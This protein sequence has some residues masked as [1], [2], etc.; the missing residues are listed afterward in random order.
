MTEG[1]ERFERYLEQLSQGIEALGPEEAAEVVAEVRA[2]L[3]EAVAGAE[4]DRESVIAQFGS[5]EVL[6]ARILEERGVVAGGGGL[7]EAPAG[8][9]WLAVLVDAL[10][11]LAE[12]LVV[13]LVLSQITVAIVVSIGPDVA[14][15]RVPFFAALALTLAAAVELGWRLRVAR[16]GPGT[17]SVGMQLLGLRRIRLASDTRVVLF[18]QVP[19]LKRISPLMPS[20]AV[21]LALAVV[22]GFGWLWTQ[23]SRVQ[24]EDAVVTA[25]QR[26]SGAVGTVTGLYQRVARDRQAVA[27]PDTYAPSAAPAIAALAARRKAGAVVAYSIDLVELTD[28][29]PLVGLPAPGHTVG[30][31]VTVDEYGAVSDTLHTAWQ[32][33]LDFGEVANA[34]GSAGWGWRITS[35]TPAAE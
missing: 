20:I 31:V 29:T 9:Q 32:Y 25:V 33:R 4:G 5:A 8:R 3:A 7:P 28:A 21:L 19:G 12:V 15:G 27:A 30:A 2:H 14:Q 13:Y 17:R 18:R 16:Q 1:N 26:V 10:V 22:A 34:D 24:G 35:V 6:A 11:W 23:G